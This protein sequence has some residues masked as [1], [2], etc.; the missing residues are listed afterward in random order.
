VF[1]EDRQRIFDAGCDGFLRKPAP[2]Q[3]IFDM[4]VQYLGVEFIHGQEEP[5]FPPEEEVQ[6]P[7]DLHSEF[8][9]LPEALRKELE[10]STIGLNVAE[11]LEIIERIREHNPA[12]ADIL[13]S[14]THDFRF[15]K[16]HDL[17][18]LD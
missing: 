15:E 11:S 17:L 4:L 10:R 1:A 13:K 3:E 12:L 7:A 18:K 2:A 16:I 14:W 6:P 5:R 8:E 9:A